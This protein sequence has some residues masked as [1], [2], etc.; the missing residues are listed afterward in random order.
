MLKKRS[1]VHAWIGNKRFSTNFI[2]LVPL[3]TVTPKTRYSIQ[4]FKQHT[5]KRRVVP[6]VDFFVNA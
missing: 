2:V 3:L 5:M 1:V 6:E 4:H